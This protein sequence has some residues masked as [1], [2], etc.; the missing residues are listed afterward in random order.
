MHLQSHVEKDACS[1][2]VTG[3]AVALR[4]RLPHLWDTLEPH[5]LV[6]GEPQV[7]G[8]LETRN[9][10]LNEWRSYFYKGTPLDPVKSV[11]ENWDGPMAG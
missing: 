2:F 1:G 3:R 5:R 9:H 4:D 6:Q 11:G 10:Y 7:D 8:L